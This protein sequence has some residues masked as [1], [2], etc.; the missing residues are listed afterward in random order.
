MD[1]SMKRKANCF[2]VVLAMILLCVFPWGP[3][4]RAQATGQTISTLS[5]SPT[6]TCCAALNAPYRPNDTFLV[7]VNVSLVTGQSM[8]GFDIRVNY[9]NPRI[10]SYS[11]GVL[12]A[13]SI[14]Y[15][16]NILSSYSPSTPLACIDGLSQLSSGC[17]KDTIG[18]VHITQ[19]IAGKILNGPLDGTLFS[20]KFQVIGFGSN[21]FAV[22]QGLLFNPN[23]DPSNPGF[24]HFQYVPT[25]NYAGVF[26]NQ[27]VTAFF[28]FQT[29]NPSASPSILPNQRAD[30]DARSSFVSNNSSMGFRLFSWDFGDG[31]TDTGASTYHFF[32]LPGN[33]TVS[34]KVSD[35]KND[36]GT[37]IRRVSVL[38]ALGNLALTIDDVQ[39]NPQRGNVVVLVFNKSSSAVPF[40]NQTTT[41]AGTVLFN[42]LI[43]GD[44]FLTF[45]GQGI[46]TSS[47]VEKVIPGWT[48]QDTVY[49]STI[50]MPPDNRGLI[51]AGTILGGLGIVAGAVFYQKRKSAGRSAKGKGRTSTRVK[52]SRT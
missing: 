37:L 40:A 51:Y 23:P 21:I 3:S 39:G 14:D 25:L 15:S 36:N 12:A 19:V 34:L 30:F 22:D 47:V 29:H 2:V 31:K 11:N 42:Q 24:F 43:P 45:S 48:A 46:K 49:L 35:D 13:K 41:Q 16:G 33:Y 5:I 27:G 10:G 28:D 8:N 6:V 18:Q 7:K 17:G 44:Y 50:P 1:L 32:S 38:P 4:L 20:I 52:N 26:G 9:T